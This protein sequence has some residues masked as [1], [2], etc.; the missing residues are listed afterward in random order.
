MKAHVVLM[1]KM[2]CDITHWKSFEGSLWQ[3]LWVKCI[4]LSKDFLSWRKPNITS[5]D[6]SKKLPLSRV[7][8]Q[9]HKT[10]FCKT[11]GRHYW[12]WI[13]STDLNTQ[14]IR[15]FLGSSVVF[16]IHGISLYCWGEERQY[17]WCKEKSRNTELITSGGIYEA[18]N[19]TSYICITPMSPMIT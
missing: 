16:L 14:L 8:L 6:L 5:L 11:E 10:V 9:Y 3:N 12:T 2:F 13:T 4:C 17:P 7:N 1:S 19:S 15:S 18:V